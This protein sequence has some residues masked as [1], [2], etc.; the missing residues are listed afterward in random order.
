MQHAITCSRAHHNCLKHFVWWHNV[1]NMVSLYL[2]TCIVIQ[3]MIGREMHQKKS[4]IKHI[5]EGKNLSNA[6]IWLPYTILCCL[7]GK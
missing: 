6:R 2:R 3:Y 4:E 1:I 7:G 5:L